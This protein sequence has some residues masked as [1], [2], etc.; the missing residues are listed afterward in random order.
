MKRMTVRRPLASRRGFTL[1]ELLVVISIIATLM[2]LVLPAVQSARAAARKL[3]CGNNLKQLTLAT[4]NFA[5]QKNGQLPFLVDAPPNSALSGIGAVSFHLALFPQMDQAGAVES[6][7]QQTTAAGAQTATVLVMQTIYKAL[8]CPDDNN[9]KSQPGGNSYVA[10]AGYANYGA[11]TG[12]VVTPTGTHSASNYTG[13]PHS[14]LTGA[15]LA[16]FNRQVNRATGVFWIPDADGWRASLDAIVSGDGSGQPM[17][18]RENT[19]A[20]SLDPTVIAPSAM[21]NGFVIGITSLNLPPSMSPANPN[22]VLA[23]TSPTNPFL[24]KVNSNKGSLIGGSPIPSS[25]HP[26][27][28]NVSYCDGHV[29][30]LSSD[31]NGLVYASLMT[32]SGIRYGQLPL[33]NDAP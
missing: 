2:S 30:F 22:M 15:A 24:F 12:G 10:N 14:L 32:P 16:Q 1:I 31:I 23:G 17:M 9:H 4:T 19:N 8:T 27:G 13:W 18:Y 6:I 25:L 28:V 21:T 11:T 3:E 29:G 20:G 26:G 7:E 33:T 5:G